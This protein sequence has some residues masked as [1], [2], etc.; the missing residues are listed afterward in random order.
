MADKKE[1][2]DST[3]PQGA[4]PKSFNLS[5]IGTS[6]EAIRMRK[7]GYKTAAATEAQTTQR[8][9]ETF[10]DERLRLVW[11]ELCDSLREKDPANSER[12]M[13]LEVHISDFPKV[14]VAITNQL[15]ERYMISNKHDIEVFLSH[16]LKN[17]DLKV[18]FRFAKIEEMESKGLTRSEAFA[19]L[20]KKSA[21]VAALQRV[22]NLELV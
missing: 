11:V 17:D 8:L 6:M 16:G 15:L 14:E 12:M 7:D 20:L 19:E 9:S 18:D 4:R 5:N 13:N 21:G 3:S 2:G 1:V 22:F 10:D